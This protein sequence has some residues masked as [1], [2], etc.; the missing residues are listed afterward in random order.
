MSCEHKTSASSFEQNDGQIMAD[1]TAPPVAPCACHYIIL[2]ASLSL[3]SMQ[4]HA[5]LPIYHAGEYS[6]VA[7]WPSSP[8]QSQMSVSRAG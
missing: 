3:L 5:I 2:Q 7:A 4:S 1:V 6:S 8:R